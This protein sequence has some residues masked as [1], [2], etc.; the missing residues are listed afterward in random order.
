[1]T[2][3]A[4][5]KWNLFL[6]WMVMVILVEKLKTLRKSVSLSSMYDSIFTFGI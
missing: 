3:A 4:A 2:M 5:D 6:C 1:M